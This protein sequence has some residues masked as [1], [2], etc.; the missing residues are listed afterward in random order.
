[1]YFVLTRAVLANEELLWNFKPVQN[2]RYRQFDVTAKKCIIS[3]SCQSDREIPEVPNSDPHFLSNQLITPVTASKVSQKSGIG[4]GARGKAAAQ[5]DTMSTVFV[6][7]LSPYG[8]SAAPIDPGLIDAS[9][10]NVDAMQ[11]SDD[12]EES[13]KS[14][15][16]DDTRIVGTQPVYSDFSFG[17]VDLK[18]KIKINWEVQNS[19]PSNVAV[20]P[21]IG[22]TKLN[23]QK[24]GFAFHARK[25]E[26]DCFI[27][28]DVPVNKKLYDQDS[29]LT[30]TNKAI[31]ADVNRRGEGNMTRLNH[32]NCFFFYFSDQLIL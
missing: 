15:D 10:E 14:S 26:L 20:N 8:T 32:G 4:G 23:W 12:S 11:D 1:V 24:S 31:S 22:E 9:A 17:L 21:F 19:I 3:V 28:M 30:L 16:I 7:E 25:T 18:R 27:L 5:K 2:Y 6:P 13:Q 29:I